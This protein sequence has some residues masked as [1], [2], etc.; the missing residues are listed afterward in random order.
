MGNGGNGGNGGYAGDLAGWLHD[1]RHEPCAEVERTGRWT[2]RVSV[3]DGMTVWGPYG[4]GWLVVGH[5]RAQRKARRVLA[6]YLKQEARA[7]EVERL[8][9]QGSRPHPA[10]G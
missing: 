10:P 8:D 6:R 5:K 2:Y 9:G 4:Y 3:T 7:G 1:L